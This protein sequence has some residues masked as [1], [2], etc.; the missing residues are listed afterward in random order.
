LSAYGEYTNTPSVALAE[1]EDYT[2]YGT[3]TLDYAY[4]DA[5][6]FQLEGRWDSDPAVKI[7]QIQCL[8]RSSTY[9]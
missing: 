6:A 1:A 7:Y 5:T 8:C 2:Y 9:L 4:S 3:L